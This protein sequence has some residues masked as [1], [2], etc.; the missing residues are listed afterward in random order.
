MSDDIDEARRADG[1][2]D[3]TPPLG[4]PLTAA[5]IAER[6][7]RAI[8]EADLDQLAALLSPDVHW[9][10]PDDPTPPCR[11]RRQ[12]LRWYA[13]GRAKGRRAAV[14]EVE[15]HGDCLLVGL[16][17]DDGAER[18]QVLRVGPDGVNDVRGYEDRPRALERMPR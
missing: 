1:R 10:A 3:G 8:D 16:R 18:W 17:L 5:A 9:G 6:V 14:T 7:R 4:A 13:A 15:V 12:V 11:N 2:P